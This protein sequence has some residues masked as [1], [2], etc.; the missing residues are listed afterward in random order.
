MAVPMPAITISVPIHTNAMSGLVEMSSTTLA[1]VVSG[2]LA[3]ALG[4]P[5]YFALTFLLTLP[6]MA[7]IPWLP[8]LDAPSEE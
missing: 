6:N 7:M 4:F 2:F 3:S 8:H 5:I 1:G